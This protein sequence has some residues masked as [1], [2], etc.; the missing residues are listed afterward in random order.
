MKPPPAPR[1]VP[2][3]LGRTGL[4]VTPLAVGTSP[5]AGMTRQ[6]GYDVAG[7]R[8]VATLRAVFACPIDFLDTANGYG[9][10]GAA[11]RRIGIAIQE[12]GGLPPGLV[13][14]TKVD[15]DPRTRDFSGERVWASFAESLER[16]GL[17]RVPLLYL[18][19][20]E[21]L[22]FTEATA[23]GGPLEALLEL[24]RR[25]LVDH[26]GVAGGKVSVL[27]EYV[28]TGEF[29]VILCHNRF[30]LL[31]RSCAGLFETARARGMGVVNAA[32]YGGGML[33][34]GP[35]VQARYAYGRRDS[36]IAE[37]AA[38]MQTAC[39]RRGIPL[40]AAALQFSMRSQTIDSTVV[41]ISSPE[42]VAETLE[43]ATLEIPDRLWAELEELTPPPEL[44]LN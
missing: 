22:V 19:D 23:P 36:R 42:R 14:A 28:D 18:H 44:W 20:P 2:R 38:A 8:A 26:L 37:S 27:R 33:A 6:Y 30:T 34:K 17:E 10:D 41:G 35:A 29:E 3:P 4:L 5:L 15:P 24:R 32:P 39:A 9:E 1:L 31:D 11:E 25:G 21:R 16:L 7:E 13:V 43:L 12:A 40:A